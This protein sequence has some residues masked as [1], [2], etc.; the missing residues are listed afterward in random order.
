MTV[1]AV[2]LRRLPGLG[3]YGRYARLVGLVCVWW[4]GEERD[5]EDFVFWHLE[6]FEL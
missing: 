3:A 5:G 1:A 4:F 2:T 6:N